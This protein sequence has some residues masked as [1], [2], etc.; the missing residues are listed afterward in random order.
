[1]DKSQA[2]DILKKVI[3][4]LHKQGNVQVTPEV[5]EQISLAVDVLEDKKQI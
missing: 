5:F 2:I 1:M 4:S 3:Q